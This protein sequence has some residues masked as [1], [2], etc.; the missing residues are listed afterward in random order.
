MGYG[1][2]EERR[3][4]QLRTVGNTTVSITCWQR[5]STEVSAGAYVTSI[6]SPSPLTVK[7]RTP[8]SPAR[9][10]RT[11]NTQRLQS[12]PSIFRVARRTRFAWS[13]GASEITR[14]DGLTQRF[15]MPTPIRG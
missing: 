4:N 15:R 3:P 1:D 8:S 5:T 9:A 7:S 2:D 12:K 11:F 6:R 10:R 14:T 13:A